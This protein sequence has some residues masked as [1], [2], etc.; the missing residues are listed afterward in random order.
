M[1]LGT[2]VAGFPNLFLIAGPGTP[3]V[4]TNTVVAIEQHADFVADCIVYLRDRD[5]PTIEAL[6]DAESNWVDHVNA[7]AH[8]TLYP[9]ANSWYMGANIPGK[10]RIFMPYVGGLSAFRQ[11]CEAAA[12][13]GYEGFLLGRRGG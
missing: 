6:P 5:I 3:A 12:A 7:V 8:L 9:R 2:G 11:K 1:Y 4:L 13:A 10:P